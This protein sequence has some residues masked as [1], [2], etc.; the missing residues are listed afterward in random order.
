[1]SLVSGYNTTKQQ[2][3]WGANTYFVNML[4]TQEYQ[5]FFL[6]ILF[7]LIFFSRSIATKS[8]FS[9]KFNCWC[10][11]QGWQAISL[12]NNC[13]I[14]SWI[15]ADSRTKINILIGNRSQRFWTLEE[16]CGILLKLRLIQY[17]LKFKSHESNKSYHH[18]IWKRMH[19]NFG[20][21]SS[22]SVTLGL[23]SWGNLLF[24]W[25]IRKLKFPRGNLPS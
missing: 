15:L 13:V 6:S 18:M 24:S 10:A 25:W 5:Y 1:M 7:N 9:T 16:N 4:E 21:S 23:L 14:I 17:Q 19:C 2:N 11:Q 3:I 22:H 8:Y 20:V 12:A